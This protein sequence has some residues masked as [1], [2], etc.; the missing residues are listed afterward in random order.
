[1]EIKKNNLIISSISQEIGKIEEKME[2][3]KENDENIKISFSS[4]YMMDALRAIDDENI[5]MYLNGEIKPIILQNEK[6]DELIQL[7]L[8]IKTF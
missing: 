8:P 1:M 5:I 6:N 4:K 2:I 7:V 3:K